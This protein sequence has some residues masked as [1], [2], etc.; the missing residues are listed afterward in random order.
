MPLNRRKRTP[1]KNRPVPLCLAGCEEAAECNSL[2]IDLV[3]TAIVTLPGRSADWYAAP[4]GP[5][6]LNGYNE[7]RRG[8]H[9]VDTGRSIRS[10]STG[11]ADCSVPMGAMQAQHYCGASPV[12]PLVFL[13]RSEIS[14]FVSV[15]ERMMEVGNGLQSAKPETSKRGI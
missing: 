7:T 6:C 4:L 15:G 1:P 8:A 3:I 11:V 5:A 14:L 10:R 12:R 2:D 13:P 9:H